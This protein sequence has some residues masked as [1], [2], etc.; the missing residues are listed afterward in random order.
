[1]SVLLFKLRHVPDDEANDIRG[2]LESNNLDY[3]ETSEGNWGISTA[4]IWL[5]NRDDL[6]KAKSLID[7]Y[8]QERGHNQR[9]AYFKL[10]NSGQQ[11]TI[12]DVIKEN[13]YRFIAYITFIFFLLYFSIKPFISL[14]Q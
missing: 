14:H 2:L 5:K 11:K 1:M 8:Q 9:E 13:P 7:I 3:Y 4:A 6:E 10:K 12:L